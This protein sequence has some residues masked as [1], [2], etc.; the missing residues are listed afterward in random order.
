MA[1]ILITFENILN[2]DALL[3]SKEVQALCNHQFGGCELSVGETDQ[4]EELHDWLNDELHKAINGDYDQI[5][6]MKAPF[7][8]IKGENESDEYSGPVYVHLFEPDAAI[9]DGFLLFT[10]N[11]QGSIFSNNLYVIGVIADEDDIQRVMGS[12]VKGKLIVTKKAAPAKEEAQSKDPAKMTTQEVVNFYKD[13][14]KKADAV[15]NFSQWEAVEDKERA[16]WNSLDDKTKQLKTVINAKEEYD[17]KSFV[18][19]IVL[20]NK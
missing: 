14:I 1:Q 4:A 2:S 19:S 15:R 11:W 7:A 8:E 12:K 3:E 20:A 9:D 16:F 17:N 18:M 5:Y 13:L 6:R 10:C